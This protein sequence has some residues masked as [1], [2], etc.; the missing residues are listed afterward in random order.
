MLENL[1]HEIE[2]M[3]HMSKEKPALYPFIYESSHRANTAYFITTEYLMSMADLISLKIE[4]IQS[5]TTNEDELEKLRLGLNSPI[6]SEA[7]T[8]V[9]FTD[10]VCA[11]EY[12]H[13]RGFLN[14]EIKSDNTFLKRNGHVILGD[15]GLMVSESDV[16]DNNLP[17]W[18]SFYILAF[19]RQ[20]GESYNLNHTRGQTSKYSDVF[21]LGVTVAEIHVGMHPHLVGHG[22]KTGKDDVKV[23]MSNILKD[24][25]ILTNQTEL[26]LLLTR[27]LQNDKKQRPS[28]SSVMNDCYFEGTNWKL[29]DKNGYESPIIKNLKESN[30]HKAILE[31]EEKGQKLMQFTSV[32]VGNYSKYDKDFNQLTWKAPPN[33]S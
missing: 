21:A 6:F 22:K 9:I 16:R 20:Q 8:R 12:L 5:T 26:Q 7:E 10:L 18:E 2:F 15:F 14:R 3:K 25:K 17:A 30:L 13:Y 33:S 23:I 31:K 1:M 4:T 11:V 19:E 32:S 29:V 24:R 27:M 28:L